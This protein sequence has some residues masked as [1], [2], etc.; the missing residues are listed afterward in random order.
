MPRCNSGCGALGDLKLGSVEKKSRG[1]DTANKA[2]RWRGLAIVLLII[3]ALRMYALVLHRPTLGYANQYDMLRTSACVDLWPGSVGAQLRDAQLEAATTQAPQ[4]IYQRRIFDHRN[5]YW[6]TD[7]ALA[8]LA[9]S[10]QQLGTSRANADMDLRW[11]GGVKT[12]V[13][14]AAMVWLSTLLWQHPR[15]AALNALIAA[16]VL[17]DPLVMLYANTLYTEFGAVLGAYLAVA[18]AAGLTLE[19]RRIRY[20][21]LAAGLLLGL[22]LLGSA[23]VPHAPL[24]AA[25]VPVMLYY[26]FRQWG[27]FPYKLAC[28]L[29]LPVALGASVAA[30]NQ[31]ALAGVAQANASNTLFFTMLPAADDPRAFAQDLR[32]RP[33]CGELAFSSWYLKRASDVARDCPEAYSFSR[34]RLA[35]VLAT[36][37]K[38][39][40]RVLA[41]AL[42][43]SRGWRMH[44]VGEVAGASTLR[45]PFWS[46]ADLAP[47]LPYPLYV[48]LV[49][50]ALSLAALF[51]LSKTAA[52]LPQR[53][54]LALLCIAVV[55]PM[56]I[57]L[58]GDGY[59]ELPRHAHLSTVAVATLLLVLLSCL[60]QIG[61]RRC[62][63]AGILSA[64]F[65]ILLSRQPAA[66][67]AWDHPLTAPVAA[68]VEIS[69]WV[70]DAYGATAVYGSAPGQAN[71]ALTFSARPGVTA[72]FQGYPNDERA[73]VRGVL[74]ITPPYTEIRVGNA[75]GVETVVDRIWAMPRADTN[76]SAY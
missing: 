45:A 42:A 68:R 74:K 54:L 11:L 58:L 13:L 32:L 14:L 43:Q 76:T 18:S 28:A 60:D 47:K 65:V 21:Q 75:L 10:V 73:G 52:R 34:I 20:W 17:A 12:T 36:Q 9:M 31:H 57:S 56:L 22:A 46:L 40:L 19:N 7:V 62:L 55:L 6:S 66:I 44:Y 8:A 16:L 1:S 70:L 15:A 4:P 64:L 71:Q 5:C 61:V 33:Q 26:F 27:R 29:L 38:I 59:T 3:A 24:V 72:V 49:L 23:R 30:R 53:L 35:W 37:P 50:F 63:A 48:G 51:G 69:G 25:L 41:N 67:A 39:G 2:R